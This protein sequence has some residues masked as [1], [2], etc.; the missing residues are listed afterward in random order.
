MST[1]ST[2]TSTFTL[3]N[4]RYVTSKIKT[5]LKLLQK[6]YGAPPDARI[7]A[8]GE[9]A[10]LL[11]KDGYLGTVTY[12]YRRNESWVVALRYTAHPNGTLVADDRAGGVPRGVDISRASFYS[13]LTYSAKW[14][15]LSTSERDRI[16]SLLPVARTTGQEPGTSGGF[17]RADRSYSHNGTGLARGAFRTL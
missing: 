10:A 5:D 12:G 8:F 9:E 4:A 2:R 1:T 7:E 14:D 13:Y 11:L 3:A 16:E 17:W 6:A 15:S